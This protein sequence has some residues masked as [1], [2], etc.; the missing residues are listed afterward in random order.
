MVS[1]LRDTLQNR[2]ANCGGIDLINRRSEWSD[3]SGVKLGKKSD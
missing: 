2:N 3:K 1:Y